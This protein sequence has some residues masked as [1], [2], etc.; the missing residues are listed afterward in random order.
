M[1]PQI[2]VRGYWCYRN[3]YCTDSYG[4]SLL[5]GGRDYATPPTLIFG[6]GQGAQGAAEIDTW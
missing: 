5:Q 4:L 2:L 6:G 1:Q 3:T